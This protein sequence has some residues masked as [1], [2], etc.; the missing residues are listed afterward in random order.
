MYT[1]TNIQITIDFFSRR[2]KKKM[3]PKIFIKSQ[4]SGTFKLVD[5]S[6]GEKQKKIYIKVHCSYSFLSLFYYIFSMSYY[7]R[8]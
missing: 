4:E 3:I 5:K 8:Q 6:A 7:T 2:Y 1:K